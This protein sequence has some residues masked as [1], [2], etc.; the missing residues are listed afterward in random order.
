M[1]GNKKIYLLLAVELLVLLACIISLFRVP[2]TVVVEGQELLAGAGVWDEGRGGWYIDASYGASDAFVKTPPK[3][4]P[5]GVYQVEVYYETDTDYVNR[6][7]V[8]DPAAAMKSLKTN[9]ESLFAGL[10]KIAYELWVT[11]GGGQLEVNVSFGGQGSLLV[12]SIQLVG[13]NALARMTLFLTVLFI[14]CVNIVA[15]YCMR[16]KTQDISDE[17]KVIIAGLGAILF[18]SSFPLMTDYIIAGGDLTFHLLRIEGL[19]DGLLAGEFPVRIDSGWQHG[20]GYAT[21]VFYCDTFLTIPALLRIIGFNMQDSYKAFLFVLNVGA[22]INSYL[23]FKGIT[24]DKYLGLMGSMMYTL[25][26]FRIHKVY[27]SAA[28][29]EATSITFV[30]LLIWGFYKIF[31]EDVKDKSYKWNWIIPT[32]GFCGMLQSHILSTYIVAIFTILLCVIMIKRVFRKETFLVLATIVIMSCLL[33]AWF[34]VPF[35]DYMSSQAF[36]VNHIATQKIQFRGLQIGQLFKVFFEAGNNSF[37]YDGGMV[38]AEPT[39][40]GGV[41]IAG[42]FVFGLLL[43]TGR[44]AGVEKRTLQTGKLAAVLAMLAMALSTNVFPWDFVQKLGSVAA[45][46]SATL[47]LPSRFLNLATALLITVTCI[48]GL[49]IWKSD[50]KQWKQGFVVGIVGLTLISNV[51]LINDEMNEKQFYRLYNVGG[52]GTGYVSGAE[53]ILVGTDPSQYIYRDPIAGEGVEL[54]GYEKDGLRIEVTCSNYGGAES[55]IDMPLVGYEGYRAYDENGEQLPVTH[56][57]NKVVRVL[58]PADYTGEVSV[59]FVSPWYW[60]VAEAVT[61]FTMIALAATGI[62]QRRKRKA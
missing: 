31:T 60:R 33:S 17:N 48:A 44:T 41:L 35:L 27:H 1:K 49:C 7:T 57:E 25:S 53:Y 36:A 13:T 40:L 2:E 56:G 20:F 6:S 51:Y 12:K 30:P 14:S 26:I 62:Y 9:G 32:I 43:W 10:D 5:A 61:L 47:I 15:V 28:L 59:R 37:Y 58:I 18:L 42:L 11:D 34:L 22:C 23:A 46:L 54:E 52:M 29:G 24:K 4:I 16:R 3:P 50:N 19:K 39:G 21:P 38:D 8:A 55:Y 45:A